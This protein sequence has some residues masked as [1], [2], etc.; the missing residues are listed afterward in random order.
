MGLKAYET[1]GGVVRRDLFA[2]ADD[3]ASVYLDDPVLLQTLV[4]EKL[5]GLAQ[6]VRAEGW[7]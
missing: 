5:R 7:S 3:V 1:R 2:E 4:F 6:E